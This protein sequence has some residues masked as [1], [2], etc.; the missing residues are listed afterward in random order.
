MTAYRSQLIREVET[1]L[2]RARARGMLKHRGMTLTDYKAER[3]KQR[4]QVYKVVIV[5][6]WVIALVATA[7]MA[8]SQR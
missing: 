2:M 6:V 4:R 8:W 5:A 7:L 1:D 3:A